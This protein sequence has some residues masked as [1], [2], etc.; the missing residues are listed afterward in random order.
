MRR[1]NQRP[2]ESLIREVQEY[3]SQ[4]FLGYFLKGENPPLKTCEKTLEISEK[5]RG[6]VNI[7]I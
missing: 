1:P 5:M 6:P 4:K 7:F 3:Y 2:K